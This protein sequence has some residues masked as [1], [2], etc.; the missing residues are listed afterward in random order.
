MR[1]CVPAPGVPG[2]RG[3][4]SDLPGV[5]EED[6]FCG[7][8]KAGDNWLRDGAGVG[9]ELVPRGGSNQNQGD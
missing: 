1:R 2:V 7:A 8:C 5:D 9:G 6:G 3:E 4:G